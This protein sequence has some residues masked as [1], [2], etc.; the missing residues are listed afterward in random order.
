MVVCRYRIKKS[1]KQNKIVLPKL[2]LSLIYLNLNF[3]GFKLVIRLE[4]WFVDKKNIRWTARIYIYISADIN[5]IY[6]C[7]FI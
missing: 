6:V 1:I 7:M 3:N 5:V 4:G 2:V